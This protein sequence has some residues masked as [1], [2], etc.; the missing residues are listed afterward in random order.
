MSTS[1]SMP[2]S[3]T[4]YCLLAGGL[5]ASVGAYKFLSK[6]VDNRN[7]HVRSMQI[8]NSAPSLTAALGSPIRLNGFVSGSGVDD[9][10]VMETTFAVEGPL[11]NA[12]ATVVARRLEDGE[13]EHESVSVAV[14]EQ[15]LVVRGAELQRAWSPLRARCAAGRSGPPRLSARASVEQRAQTN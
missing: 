2:G 3:V 9:P 8:I 10:D 5:V 11:G 4:T 12:V 13:W 14:G 1:M 15:V 6:S 7:V